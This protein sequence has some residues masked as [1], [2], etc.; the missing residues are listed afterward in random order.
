MF[1]RA[2]SGVYRN[3]IRE[4]I[5]M[6]EQCELVKHKHKRNAEVVVIEPP[7]RT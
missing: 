4:A 2:S 6:L 7:S 3:M 1:F 5:K